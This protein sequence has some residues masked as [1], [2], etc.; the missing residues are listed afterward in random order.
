MSSCRIGCSARALPANSW[1]WPRPRARC[2][3]M[4]RGRAAAGA[5]Y[6]LWQ[7]LRGLVAVPVFLAAATPVLPL[8]A[9]VVLGRR[10]GVALDRLLW[11]ALRHHTAGTR[12]VAAPGGDGP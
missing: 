2:M 6:G 7:A 5:L 11:A 10:D 8:V 9:A 12:R 1:S 3:G 4:G